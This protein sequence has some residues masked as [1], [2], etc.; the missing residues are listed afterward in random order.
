MFT[1]GEGLDGV[2][3]VL[4]ISLVLLGIVFAGLGFGIGFLVADVLL[5]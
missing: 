2:K 4:A 1:D 3:V 5:P